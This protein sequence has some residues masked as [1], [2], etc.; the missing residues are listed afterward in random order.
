MQKHYNQNTMKGKGI[1][2]V[3]LLSSSCLSPFVS[4][5]MHSPLY[6]PPDPVAIRKHQEQERR[7]QEMQERPQVTVKGN[8]IAIRVPNLTRRPDIPLLTLAAMARRYPHAQQFRLRWNCYAGLCI[9]HSSALYDRDHHTVLLSVTG[10]IGKTEHSIWNRSL[11]TS[12]TDRAI[13][14][15][16]N[17]HR[18]VV[19]VPP[20]F[21][22]AA[23]L[24][25]FND[26]IF[27]GCHVQTFPEPP[28]I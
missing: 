10:N 21:F 19:V 2:T 5:Q 6:V 9:S 23:P 11:F 13:A 26:L 17:R 22:D 4:A 20:N 1:I 27:Y 8:S 15:D 18:G 3:L 24:A 12:V 7:Y 16:A 28:P 14:E 25:F